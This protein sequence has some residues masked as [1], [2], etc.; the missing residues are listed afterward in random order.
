M[1]EL[2]DGKTYV[3]G[4]LVDPDRIEFGWTVPDVFEEG[5]PCACA[6]LLACYFRGEASSV[7]SWAENLAH[8][9]WLAAMWDEHV[10]PANTCAHL[11]EI[12]HLCARALT[13]CGSSYEDY[14]VVCGADLADKAVLTSPWYACLRS[15]SD[16]MEPDVPGNPQWPDVCEHV[17]PPG[18]TSKRLES[19]ALALRYLWLARLH[20]YNGRWDPAYDWMS[21]GNCLHA[22]GVDDGDPSVW[23][24]QCASM[25][26]SVFSA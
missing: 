10:D 23:P 20:E 2:R 6:S 21:A 14:Q 22:A 4:V 12:A 7:R 3:N 16:L 8:R 13:M 11:D 25:L 1:A 19:A 26:V 15:V 24:A 9:L 18:G 5:I 17:S